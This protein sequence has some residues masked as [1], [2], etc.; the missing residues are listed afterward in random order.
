MSS[1]NNNVNKLIAS[2]PVHS[3]VQPKKK[4]TMLASVLHWLT[5]KCSSL[6]STSCKNNL[7]SAVK[8]ADSEYYAKFV[9][10]NAQSVRVT[11]DAILHPDAEVLILR[12]LPQLRLT[13]VKSN[14]DEVVLKLANQAFFEF[15]DLIV[16][17]DE[18]PAEPKTTKAVRPA[19]EE[20]EVVR[21]RLP[22][23]P[24]RKRAVNMVTVSKNSN[25]PIKLRSEL[26]P[27]KSFPVRRDTDEQFT[28]RI[29]I[30]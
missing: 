9:R 14:P 19:V 22:E 7:L 13:I 8:W 6:L 27:D 20:V 30:S 15:E 3:I 18:T 23:R 17:E 10:R 24:Q 28:P 26:Q 5:N 1:I 11:L 25:R 16:P 12:P 29:P 4:W 21:T 2:L